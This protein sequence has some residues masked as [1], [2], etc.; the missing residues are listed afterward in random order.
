VINIEGFVKYSAIHEGNYTDTSDIKTLIEKLS[1]N[2]SATAKPIVVMDAGIATEKNLET[3]TRQGYKYV[4]VSRAKIKDYQPV[5]QGK[6]TYF[7]TSLLTQPSKLPLP[8]YP[9][10]QSAILTETAGWMCRL[11]RLVLIPS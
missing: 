11:S 6:E 9:I 8:V 4:V 10:W 1:H 5:Q 3:L 2:T 7:I